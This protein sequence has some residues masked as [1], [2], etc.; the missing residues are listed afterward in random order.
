MR[1]Q[2]R[3]RGLSMP[4]AGTYY[5]PTVDDLLAAVI[6]AGLARHTSDLTQRLGHAPT[7]HAFAAHLEDLLRNDRPWLIT[8]YELYLLAARRPDL[9]P[10]IRSWTEAL[11]TILSRW[12]SDPTALTT[13]IAALDGLFLQ[14]LTDTPPPPGTIETVLQRTL[15]VTGTATVPD[16]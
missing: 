4:T 2:L 10:A 3:L 1:A 7:L 12:T 5:F 11:R 8:E 14:S 6:T 16:L 9:R 13:A 15:A